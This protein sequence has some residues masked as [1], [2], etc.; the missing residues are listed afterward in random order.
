MNYHLQQFVYGQE[1]KMQ[2]RAKMDDY[3]G[4]KTLKY[5]V[6][7]ME[8]IGEQPKFDLDDAFLNSAERSPLPTQLRAGGNSKCVAKFHSLNNQKQKQIQG[9]TNLL[10]SFKKQSL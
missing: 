10:Q 7:Y 1:F 8:R 5:Y 6:C 4:E 3:E 9:Q 2:L